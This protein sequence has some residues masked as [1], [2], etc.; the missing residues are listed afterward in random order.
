MKPKNSEQFSYSAITRG[1]GKYHEVRLVQARQ[2]ISKNNGCKN[3]YGKMNVERNTDPNF[4][5]TS[6]AIFCIA[7]STDSADPLPSSEI[8]GPR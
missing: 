8:S 6:L 3:N 7:E 2:N 5:A 1:N 4:V